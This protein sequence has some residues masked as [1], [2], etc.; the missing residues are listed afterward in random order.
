VDG[1]I[2]K[3]KQERDRLTKSVSQYQSKLQAIPLREQQMTDLVRDYEIA[4]AHYKS[5]LEKQMSAETA[6]ELEIRQKG[7]RFTVLD[8]AQP[9]TR[10]TSP[11]RILLNSAGAGAGLVLG[12]ALALLTE[13]FGMSITAPE[14]L[15]AISGV[16]VLE[17]IPMI[18]THADQASRRRRLVLGLASGVLTGI[19]GFAVLVYLYR[20]RLF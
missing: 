8:P 9:G 4:K 12:L 18:R 1:E 17:V 3:Y 10:P 20:D 13:L 6:T 19:A 11:N 15:L 7:E 2:Q 5:L 14:Q 16:E